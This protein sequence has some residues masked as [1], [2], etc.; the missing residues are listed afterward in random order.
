MW[1]YL[2][3]KKNPNRVVDCLYCCSIKKTVSTC[4]SHFC[5]FSLSLVSRVCKCMRG[6]GCRM[7]SQSDGSP[8]LLCSILHEKVLQLQP[9]KKK[10]VVNTRSSAHFDVLHTAPLSTCSVSLLLRA[11]LAAA[12]GPRGDV[13]ITPHAPFV[14]I[15][16]FFFYHSWSY[17]YY[18]FCSHS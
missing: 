2:S 8:P 15:P 9:L 13:T 10:E 5:G 3:L 18:W 16:F 6:G 1:K 4:C 11:D 12:Q 14:Q 17:H 7:H